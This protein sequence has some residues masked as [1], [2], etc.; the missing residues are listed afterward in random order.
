M[1]YTVRAAERAGIS[2]VVLVVRA[3]AQGEILD[4]AM[5]TW[6]AGM[7]VEP[8]VQGEQPGT[9]PA[10]LAAA[11][12]LEGP[13]AVVNAD[14]FYD[15]S[16]LVL[17]RDHFAE[18]RSGTHVLVAYELLRTILT[19]DPVKRGLCV[20]APDGTLADLVEHH[21][22]LRQDGRFDAWPLAA[23]ELAE[24]PAILAGHE[25]VSMN[26]WGFH[27]RVLARFAKLCATAPADGREL[28]LPEILGAQVRAGEERVRVRHTTARCIGLT[29]REDLVPLKDQ[30]SALGL[31]DTLRP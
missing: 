14:D 31:L 30:L 1:D 25:P 9:V 10:V 12:A 6:P 22:R 19:A 15:T 16:A 24:H 13:F 29:H 3:E 4:H 7:R 21:I 8:V 20:E 5:R 28:L 27:P 11:P 26:L 17:L 18:D 2:S 23:P